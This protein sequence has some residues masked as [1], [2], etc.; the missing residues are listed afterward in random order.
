[1][2]MFYSRQALSAFT[3]LISLGL[4]FTYTGSYSENQHLGEYEIHFQQ[5]WYVWVFTALGLL[6]FVFSLVVVLFH[7]IAYSQWKINTGMDRW[8]EEHPNE[9]HQAG[10]IDGFFLRLRFFFQDSQMIY[11]IILAVGSF[12]GLHLDFLFFSFHMLDV[13]MQSQSLS[14]VFEALFQT[15]HQVV[16]TAFLGFSIQ[17][18]FLVIGFLIFPEGYGFADMDTSGC[19]SL[20]GCLLAHMDYGNRSAP[21]WSDAGLSWGMLAFDYMYNLLVILILSAIISGIIIDNFANMRSQLAERTDDQLNNCF[22][23]GI[24]RALMERKLVKFDHHVFQEH[25][26]WNYA[27]FLMHLKEA[28]NS[29]LNGPETFVKELMNHQDYAFYP[30][31]RALSMDEEDSEDYQE[32]NLR[33]KDLQDTVEDVKSCSAETELIRQAERDI[34]TQMKEAREAVED[35]TRRV[36]TI[37]VEV[38]DR[39][40]RS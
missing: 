34:K 16:G 39:Q 18:C 5:N 40:S 8:K 35:I 17:Y 33:I 25:Y 12:M 24:N 13:C 7:M 22:I 1:M 26:M 32:R 14:K 30:V 19:E 31:G 6:H 3:G 2:V 20:L 28:L 11:K 23:C 36:T 21:V 4:I 9:R 29:E 37:Q 27:R 10:G 15:Y 38:A